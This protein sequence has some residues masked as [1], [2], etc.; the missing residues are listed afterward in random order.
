MQNMA[1][2]FLFFLCTGQIPVLHCCSGVLNDSG[3]MWL[4]GGIGE[5][6]GGKEDG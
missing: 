6:T 3:A 4:P 1:L 2:F 5:G